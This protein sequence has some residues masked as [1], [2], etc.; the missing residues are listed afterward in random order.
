MSLN[1]STVARAAQLSGSSIYPTLERQKEV[2][3]KVKGKS[4]KV[5]EYSPSS[6]KELNV[7]QV[8]EGDQFNSR[9]RRKLSLLAP[10]YCMYPF[11]G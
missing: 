9:G 5:F 11:Q 3:Q 8:A 6:P 10:G 4:E 2:R 1:L 7:F